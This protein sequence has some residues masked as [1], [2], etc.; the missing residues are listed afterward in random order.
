MRKQV[1]GFPE[2][3]AEP[4]LSERTEIVFPRERPTTVTAAAASG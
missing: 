3:V 1:A 4:S 2:I